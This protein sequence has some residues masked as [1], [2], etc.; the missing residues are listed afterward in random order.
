MTDG[1]QEKPLPLKNQHNR[2][3]PLVPPFLPP[4]LPPSLPKAIKR[5]FCRQHAHHGD[6]HTFPQALSKAPARETEHNRDVV[7]CGQRP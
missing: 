1:T 4:S 3:Y 6:P 2:S 7:F 5:P